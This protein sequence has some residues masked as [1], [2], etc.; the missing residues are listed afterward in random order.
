MAIL[1]SFILPVLLAAI[2]ILMAVAAAMQALRRKRRQRVRKENSI[3]PPAPG[4]PDI[5]PN[6]MRG[7]PV[8]GL[9]EPLDKRPPVRSQASPASRPKVFLGAGIPGLTASTNG[10]GWQIFGDEV[11][12]TDTLFMAA[13]VYF[14]LGEHMLHEALCAWTYKDSDGERLSGAN[15]YVVR[16][17]TGGLSLANGFWA[18][19]LYNAENF[20]SPNPLNRYTLSQ[21]DKLKSDADGSVDLYIQCESPGIDKEE[22]WLPSPE[23]DFS[24]A[25]LICR[26]KEAASGCDWK[27]P[28]V[29]RVKHG[30]KFV[31]GPDEGRSCRHQEND[32]RHLDA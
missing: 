23:G 3:L 11:Y 8:N 26:S 17:V 12:G 20:F 29:D 21:C 31:G 10:D 13:A 5:D 16:I 6:G 4:S 15:R 30:N 27:P 25:M 18:L 9:V 24:L 32:K 19:T 22:N 28:A 14:G 7:K 1:S 2:F